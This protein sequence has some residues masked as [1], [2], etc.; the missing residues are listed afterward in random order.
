M[1]RLVIIGAGG[2]GKV[3][4]DCAEQMGGYKEI[5]FVDY[6]YPNIQHHS[7][8]PVVGDGETLQADH[9]PGTEYFVAIG[10]NQLRAK[11][12]NVLTEHAL[13]IATLIHPS[14]IL[15]QHLHIDAGTLICAGAVV[16]VDSKVGRGCILNTGCSVDH[17]C[18]LEDFVHIAPGVRLAGSVHL[19]TSA[20]LGLSSAVIPGCRIGENTTVGAGAIVLSDFPPNCVAVGVPARVIKQ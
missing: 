2:H 6:R 15:S 9:A 17:D 10:D 8:W 18:V 7:R 20:F 12:F 11:Y 14:A 5:C 1:T 4:A 13:P 16:N 19:G 3:A